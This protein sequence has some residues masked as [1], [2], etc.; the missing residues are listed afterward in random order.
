MSEVFEILK[1]RSSF[2][3]FVPE[4]EQRLADS[5]SFFLALILAYQYLEYQVLCHEPV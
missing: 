5:I 2:S 1:K 4:E 3:R